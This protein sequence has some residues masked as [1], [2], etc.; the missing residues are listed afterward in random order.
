M[1]QASASHTQSNVRERLDPRLDVRACLGP[2]GNVHERLGSQGG[3]TDNRRNED[4]EERRSA[5]RSQRNIHERL[6]PQGGQLGNPHNEDSEERHS[7]ARSRR[8]NSRRQATENP[9]QAQSTNTPSRQRKREGR[10]SQTNEEVNQRHPNREG[11][12]HDRPTMC[13][14]DVE[15][16]VND[17][18]QDLKTGGNLED[19]LRKEMDQAIST[20]FTPEIKQAAPP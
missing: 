13:A 11:C 9:S 10:P 14:E 2:H 1:S 5:A 20:P 12:Q 17:R 19:A 15:K 8:T 4:R 16:L 7:T 6:G 3:Q 18:L